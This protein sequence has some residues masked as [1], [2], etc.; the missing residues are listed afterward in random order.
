MTAAHEDGGSLGIHVERNA[1]LPERCADTAHVL[2]IEA[3]IERLE[4]RAAQIVATERD[5]AEHRDADER[6]Q[7][8][9]P[10]A[11]TEQ[12]HPEAFQLLSPDHHGLGCTG[13]RIISQEA[14]VGIASSGP[15]DDKAGRAG[16][17]GR[18]SGAS[19]T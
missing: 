1:G 11:Q 6:Q 17:R 16:V 3:P 15:R 9:A 19:G 4:V 10:P 5:G 18:L 13:G 12:A 8:Q 2:G 14:C 7:A